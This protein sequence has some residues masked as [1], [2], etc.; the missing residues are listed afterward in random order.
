MQHLELQILWLDSSLGLAVNQ[1]TSEGS[2]PLTPY[3]FWPVSEAWEQIRFE[4]NSKPW[5]SENE[6][7]K[8][9][10]L[11][12]DVMNKWQQSRTIIANEVRPTGEETINTNDT[13]IVGFS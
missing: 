10:N 1:K 9:L 11:V 13:T 6:R 4:L 5:L 2:L 12:V 8:L 7:I 3:Y